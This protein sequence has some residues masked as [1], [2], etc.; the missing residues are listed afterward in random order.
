[1]PQDS[2]HGLLPSPRKCFGS[3]PNRPE[4]RE[5]SNGKRIVWSFF[6]SRKQHI[7]TAAEA[8]WHIV[9]PDPHSETWQPSLLEVGNRG[10]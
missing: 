1:M 2:H 7:K 3:D 6:S 8:L 10:L 5:F 9:L 4:R